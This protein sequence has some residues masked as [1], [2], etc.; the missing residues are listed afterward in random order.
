VGPEEGR[1]FLQER[2]ASFARLVFAI[3][4][5]FFVA[6][7]LLTAAARLR[8]LVRG[9]PADPSSLFQ[10]APCL[11]FLV[12]AL[13]TRRAGLPIAVLRTIDAAGTILGCWLVLLMAVN[14]PIP[15][16]RDLMAVPPLLAT[17]LYRAAIVPS[18]MTRTISISAA[19]VAPVPLATYAVYPREPSG[20]APAAVFAINAGWNL[21]LRD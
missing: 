10:L 13:A 9:F 1:E 8:P 6:G 7:S 20:V 12:M 14:L 2:I 11:V 15:L 3:S 17:L 5:G 19:A 16:R 4:A 21:L 18:G